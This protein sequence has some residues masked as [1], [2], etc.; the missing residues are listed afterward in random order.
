[1]AGERTTHDLDVAALTAS[2]VAI[3]SVNPDLVP[4]AVGESA[5]A[6]FCAAWL[7]SRGLKVHRL[8]S[9]PGRPSVVGIARGAGGGPSL[10]LN[11]HYDTVTL[12]GYDGDPLIPRIEG[13]KLYGRGSFDM[14]ASLAGAW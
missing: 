4:G 10:M 6:D 2:L 14:K 7:A 13:G 12:A 1:M 8:E 3:P 11:G 5:I 9:R